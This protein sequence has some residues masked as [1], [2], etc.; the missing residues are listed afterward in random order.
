[1]R[2]LHLNPF[3]FPY[4]GGI[5]R[6]ILEIGR[7][8]ARRHEVFLLTAQLPDTEPQED[9]QGIHVTRLPSRFRLKRFYNP[10]L[11]SSPG[12][13]EAIRL[14]QPDV[15]DLHFRWSP[16]YAKAFQKS[17][18]ARVFTYH[19]T[20]GEGS[21]TLGFLSRIND[22]WTRRYIRKSHRI[23]CVSRFIWDDLKAHGFPEDRFALVPNGVDAA[24]LRATQGTAPAG[25]QDRLVGVGRLVRVKGYDTLIRALPDLDARLRLT[26]C[27]EGPEK[28]ALQR[29]AQQLGVQDRVDLPGWVPEAD[30]L[31]LLARCRAF[32]HPARFE[33]FG[34]A[35]LEALAMGAPVVSSNVG[36]LPEVVGDAGVLIGPDDPKALAH[37]I[38]QVDTDEA[39]RARLQGA[40][41][42]QC[43]RFS[44]DAVAQKQLK[45]Y[46]QA[47]ETSRV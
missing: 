40:A 8:H 23:N 26:L 17:K 18:A 3:F 38:A 20:Y 4:A 2:I 46:E 19:N 41:A 11:V 22:R 14:V 37:A 44:W 39:L 15:I 31:A 43:A 24:Q 32:V 6:R 47:I 10:P 1:M 13:R 25:A 27:G 5:E 34:L 45:I 12:L 29:L 33:A 7:R 28:A 36:G 9:V 30:K 35:P 42:T 16:S 21:G